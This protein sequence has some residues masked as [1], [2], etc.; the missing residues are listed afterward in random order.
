MLRAVSPEQ[1]DKLVKA[2]EKKFNKRSFFSV[3]P[4]DFGRAGIIGV[5]TVAG[6]LLFASTCTLGAMGT[7]PME[8]RAK[9]AISQIASLEQSYKDEFGAYADL[10][11]L[12]NSK[13][14][15]DAMKNITGWAGDYEFKIELSGDNCFITAVHRTRPD[16]RRAFKIVPGGKVQI[17]EK[18][19][20]A[21]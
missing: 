5:G 19:S 15:N 6:F 7:V 14:L 16:T 1:L 11:T 4:S 13:E 12:L 18:G 3:Q 20:I 2:F 8:F 17:I 21:P 10:Q 9:H